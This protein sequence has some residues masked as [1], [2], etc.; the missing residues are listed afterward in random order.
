MRH[1]TEQLQARV[2]SPSACRSSRSPRNT[3]KNSAPRPR[4]SAASS[5]V[6]TDIDVSIVQYGTG[7][8]SGPA[9]SPVCDLVGLGVAVGVGLGVGERQGDHRRARA[10]AANGTSRAGR[11]QRDVPEDR[12]VVA[13][14]HDEVPT[15]RL[16][17]ARCPRRR[18]RRM[19]SSNRWVD[20]VGLERPRHPPMS[21]DLGELG[22]AVRFSDDRA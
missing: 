22:H 19:S 11:R 6:I 20:R 12:G 21:H 4:S 17:G 16:A 8:A 3:P 5:I 2:G 13:L 7:Q 14:E 15:L 9:P 1:R 18:G 10:A